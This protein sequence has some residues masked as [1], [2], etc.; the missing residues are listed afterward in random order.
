M[1]RIAREFAP[2]VLAHGAMPTMSANATP[3][4]GGLRAARLKAGLTQERLAVEAG[5][6]GGYVRLLERGFMPA[7]SDVLPRLFAAIDAAQNSD[8]RPAS[9]SIAPNEEDITS[10]RNA[11]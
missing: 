8:E 3:R 6:S 1:S 4:C 10:V 11:A 2:V 7:H 9:R 5:C